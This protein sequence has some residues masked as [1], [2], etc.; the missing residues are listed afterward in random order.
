M[1]DPVG[2]YDLKII[3]SCFACVMREEGLFCQLSQTSLSELNS[4]RQTAIYPKG[5]VLFVEGEVPRGLFILCTGQAK[6][7]AT[8]PEGQS[9]TLQVAERGEVL[10]LSSLV[11]NIPYSATAETSV[12]SQ[13]S[14]IPRL[15]FLQFLRAHTDVAL[16]VA[17]HL[18][19]ELHNS[20]AQT[21]L[22]ALSRNT[23]VKVAHFLLD[24][25][26]QRGQGTGGTVR[27]VLHMTH[28]EIANHI[29]TSR[30]SVSR[31][32]GDFEHRGWIRVNR[33]SV[34]VLQFP[35]LRKLATVSQL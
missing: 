13:V 8:S 35:G 23:Q 29:G 10:G 17:K 26:D 30:E 9:L 3:D 18:A 21:R 31:T 14:F 7:T 25:A 20:W 34:I 11:G 6:L 4:I 24:W 16:R 27:L 15:P 1:S 33:G 19:E 12:P 5:A 22:L 2:P 28:E 32:L